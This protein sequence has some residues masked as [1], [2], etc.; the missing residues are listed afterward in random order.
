MCCSRK[1]LLPRSGRALL[2]WWSFGVSNVERRM[3]REKTALLTVEFDGANP[4][5]RHL[6]RRLP[7]QRGKLARRPFAGPLPDEFVR[8]SA[9]HCELCQPV[10]ENSAVRVHHLLRSSEHPISV[11]GHHEQHGRSF[12]LAEGASGRE[13]GE[14]A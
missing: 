11:R 8:C 6:R 7:N 3:S 9:V 1:A 5:T 10:N 2:R 4:S 13:S 12:W 14:R